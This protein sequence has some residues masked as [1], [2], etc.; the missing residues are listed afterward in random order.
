MK[1]TLSFLRSSPDIKHAN[2][3]IAVPYPGTELHEMAMKEEHGL[4][5]VIKDFSKFRRYNSAV[6]S[7]GDLS[8]DELIKILRLFIY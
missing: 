1:K 7:V 3:S 8:P 5:L 4:R 6:I 2:I